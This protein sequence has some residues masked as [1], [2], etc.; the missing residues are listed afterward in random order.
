MK[1]RFSKIQK[2]EKEYTIIIPYGG[3]DGID[4]REV[5]LKH[6]PDNL[7]VMFLQK[8]KVGRNVFSSTNPKNFRDFDEFESFDRLNWEIG[9]T[10]QDD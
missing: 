4:V 3:F 7:K 10:E 5:T 9:Y 8:D 2:G 6:D 1:Y